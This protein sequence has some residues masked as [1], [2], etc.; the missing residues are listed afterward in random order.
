MTKHNVSTAHFNFTDSSHRIDTSHNCTQEPKTAVQI[1]SHSS[2]LRTLPHLS[3]IDL[4]QI[5]CIGFNLE[6][7]LFNP[8]FPSVK[9]HYDHYST[10]VL[11][12]FHGICRFSKDSTR[13]F[14][15]WSLIIFSTDRLI[16]C[17]SINSRLK[18]HNKDLLSWCN[19]N[20]LDRNL[21]KCLQVYLI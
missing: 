15:P 5:T 3:I 8:T 17:K 20:C 9:S 18:H 1:L 14:L 6:S 11:L 13:L 21:F 4:L 12:R 2:R 19:N 10:H 16:Q 7:N